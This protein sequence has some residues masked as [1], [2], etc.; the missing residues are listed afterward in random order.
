[1]RSTFKITFYVNKGKE[2]NGIVPVLG[3]ITISGSIAQFSCKQSI[4]PKLWDAKANRATGR[5]DQALKVNRALD[6]IRVQITK[7]YQRISDRV[8]YVNAEMVRNAWQGIGTE[9][10]SLLSALDKH[11]DEF[12]KRTGKD[13]SKA[14]LDKYLAVRRHLADFIRSHY[15]RSDLHLKEITEDFI[16]DFSLYLRITLGLSQSTVWL[17]CIPLKMIVTKAHNNGT[18]LANPFVYYHV[19]QEMKE[20]GYLSED[21]LKIMI[22][23]S[24]DNPRLELVRDIFIFAVFTGLSYI[25]IKNL[26][27]DKIITLP[28]G[29]KWI[30]THRAKT[31][32]PV[33]VK[34][35]DVPLYIIRKYNPDNLPG[36]VF[37]V[38]RNSVCNL[39]LKDI[40]KA[41]GI[42]RHVSFHQSRHSFATLALTKG[43]PIESVSR[44]LGHTNITTTQIY[45]KITNEKIGRDMDMLS[46]KLDSL[47]R[48]ASPV[49]EETQAAIS[50]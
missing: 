47:T 10:E 45:A 44:M 13:R 1:M 8:S 2:K 21:E 15:R 49:K 16:K 29:S 26:T 17:Y 7:H 32:T 18:I 33:N 50:V 5:S 23:H 46:T 28:D 14:T 40:A 39:R 31:K 48:L 19:P 41:C 37:Q 30:A 12:K 27:A 24:F 34:L 43:V 42:D 25:D 22:A 38:P 9:Y 35:L 3:R 20:R 11:N 36:L 4:D 6:N